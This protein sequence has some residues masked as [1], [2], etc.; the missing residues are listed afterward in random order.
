MFLTM[1]F[2][3][4]LISSD[5]NHIANCHDEHCERCIIIHQAETLVRLLTNV[6]LY[7]FILPYI[8]L[9]VI[10]KLINNNSFISNTLVNSKIQFNE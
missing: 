4:A 2:L 8:L 3:S 10:R 7:I 5:I 9:L 1:F 6:G